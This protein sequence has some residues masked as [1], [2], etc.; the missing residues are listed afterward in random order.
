MKLVE[1]IRRHGHLEA[2]IFPV[3]KQDDRYSALVD[4]KKYDLTEGDLKQLDAK[5]LTPKVPS[6][7]R[8]AWDFVQHLKRNI[9]ERF[10]TNLIIFL[11]MMNASGSTRK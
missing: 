2:D 9:Q 3:G 10:H 8:N 4:P 11:T 1:A 5:L 7:V 6:N